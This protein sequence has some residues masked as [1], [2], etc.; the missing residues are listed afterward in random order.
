MT[1][2]THNLTDA[3]AQKIIKEE[4][5]KAT[6]QA[7]DRLIHIVGSDDEAWLEEKFGQI[8]EDGLATFQLQFVLSGKE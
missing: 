8:I 5:I 1:N 6:E 2:N 7:W 3:E 4:L